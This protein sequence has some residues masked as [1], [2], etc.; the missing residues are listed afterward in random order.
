MASSRRRCPSARAAASHSGKSGLVTYGAGSR[1]MTPTAGAP[2]WMSYSTL[3]ARMVAPPAPVVVATTRN[4][5][6]LCTKT[7]VAVSS[8][9]SAS[10]LGLMLTAL[11]SA[12][13]PSSADQLVCVLSWGMAVSRRS[14]H[15]TWAGQLLD[16]IGVGV[17]T[18]VIESTPLMK[19]RPYAGLLLHSSRT[20]AIPLSEIQMSAA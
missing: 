12:P 4:W 11:E 2:G 6:V 18:V 8:S 9:E 10:R 3:S 20:A 16:G 13:L 19:I 5:P 14:Y 1:V 15:W 17:A 7:T